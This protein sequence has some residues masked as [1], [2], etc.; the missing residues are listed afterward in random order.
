[1]NKILRFRLIPKLATLKKEKKKAI[2]HVGYMINVSI[3]LTNC[4]K[5]DFLEMQLCYIVELFYS[6]VD[7]VILA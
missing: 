5:F 4:L 7:M 6:Y 2:Q 3:N 1:M